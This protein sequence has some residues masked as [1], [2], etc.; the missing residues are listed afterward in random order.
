[1]EILD[2]SWLE[3]HPDLASLRN[4]A[5][6]EYRTSLLKRPAPLPP[7]RG[8]ASSSLDILRLEDAGWRAGKF[9]RFWDSLEPGTYYIRLD[10]FLKDFTFFN[11][12]FGVSKFLGIFNVSHSFVQRGGVKYLRLVKPEPLRKGASTS[13]F[14]KGGEEMRCEVCGKSCA[15]C[16]YEGICT[17]CP[18]CAPLAE[19]KEGHINDIKIKPDKV[20]I[21]L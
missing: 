17:C 16:Q 1:M 8:F 3:I 15:G 12:E 6:Q 2:L 5:I 20:R 10:E 7:V 9:I 11:P 19:I 21:F 4:F 13:L 18:E 14:Q